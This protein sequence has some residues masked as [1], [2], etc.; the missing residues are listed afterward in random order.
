[1]MVGAFLRFHGLCLGYEV[2]KRM[3]ASRTAIQ[4]HLNEKLAC[5]R[6][7]GPSF[8]NRNLAFMI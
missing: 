5:A 6:R 2:T 4:G 1:M 7:V 3:I 8:G